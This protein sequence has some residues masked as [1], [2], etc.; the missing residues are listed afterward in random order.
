MKIC[1]SFWYCLSIVK[2]LNRF[3]NAIHFG[4]I[5]ICES[6]HFIHYDRH[7]VSDSLFLKEIMN[8]N[9]F[10]S[11]SPL[12]GIVN[13]FIFNSSHLIDSLTFTYNYSRYVGTFFLSKN[14]AN[15]ELL[16]TNRFNSKDSCIDSLLK[17]RI[18]NWDWMEL[19]GLPG[20]SWIPPTPAGALWARAIPNLILFVY[21]NFHSTR[22]HV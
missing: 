15:H 17:W 9:W 7:I 4:R 1:F 5:V 13:R 18:V 22:R 8:Q 12:T 6:I 2:K 11:F 19:F 21:N 10:D 14:G 16:V 20:E 3:A